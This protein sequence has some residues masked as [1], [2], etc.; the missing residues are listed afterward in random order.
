MGNCRIHHIC[1]NTDTYEE[2]KNFYSSI[3]GFEV[4][5]ENI[6]FHNR[7]FNSWLKMG[8]FYIE[9]QTPKKGDSLNAWSKNNSGPIHIGFIVEDVKNEYKRIKNLGY[10]NF[11]KKNGEEMYVIK[12]SKIFKVMAPEGTEIE[13]RE[14]E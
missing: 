4:V 6:K 8:Q 7:A 14:I 3:I 11:K 13:Y 10:T 12:G 2:S 9:L 1:I 5:K